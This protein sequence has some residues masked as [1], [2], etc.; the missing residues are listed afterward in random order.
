MV[1][2]R[3]FAFVTLFFLPALQAI[4]IDTEAPQLQAIRFDPAVVDVTDGPA[5]VRIEFDIT[6][7]VSGFRFASLR[8]EFG[9]TRFITGFFGD[10]IYSGTPL[11]GTYVSTQ[12]IPFGS[13][14]GERVVSIILVDNEGREKLYNTDASFTVMNRGDFDREKPTVNNLTIEPQVV[15]LTNGP[16]EVTISIE[17]SDDFTGVQQLF[18][19][20]NPTD[21]ASAYIPDPARR[22]WGITEGNERATI[23]FRKLLGAYTPAGEWQLTLSNIIDGVNRA[24]DY[25]N[26]PEKL[27]KD[28]DA[29]FE[30]INPNSDTTPPKLISVEFPETVANTVYETSFLPWR[31]TFED[32]PSGVELVSVALYAPSGAENY[33]QSGAIY[34]ELNVVDIYGDTF[35]GVIEVPIYIQEGQHRVQVLM[36]DVA[37]NRATYGYGSTKPLP[38]G[39]T[40]FITVEESAGTDTT[41]ILVTDFSLSPDPVD[42]SNGPQIVTFKLDFED[43]L[44][45]LK[46][47]YLTIKDSNG[48]SIERATLNTDDL[49]SGTPTNGTLF[50]AFE[51]PQFRP[52]GEYRVT[53]LTTIDQA[54]NYFTDSSFPVFPVNLPSNF[55]VINNGPVETEP[56][57]ILSFEFP[58]TVIEITG[59]RQRFPVIMRAQ[60][61]LSGIKWG[62]V[63]YALEDNSEEIIRIILSAPRD[64]IGEQ[65]LIKTFENRG[66]FR[67][68]DVPGTYR[69]SELWIQDNFGL[70]RDYDIKDV[71][72]LPPGLPTELTLINPFPAD[73]GPPQFTDIRLSATEFDVSQYPGSLT[74]EIDFTEDTSGLDGA[75]IDLYNRDEFYR[76]RLLSTYSSSQDLNIVSGDRFQGTLKY[77]F[78]I[79]RFIPPGT[80]EVQ[81]ELQDEAFK[82]TSIDGNDDDFPF[83]DR[84]YIMITNTGSVDFSDPLLRDLTIQETVDVSN[85]PAI[86]DISVEAID[87][88]AGVGQ[89]TLQTEGPSGEDSEIEVLYPQSE[90]GSPIL[91]GRFPLSIE[92]PAFAEPGEWK[93]KVT[94]QDKNNGYKKY[95][96]VDLKRWG[97]PS[98]LTVINTQPP[99]YLWKESDDVFPGGWREV[100]WFGW[101]Q[102]QGDYPFVYHLE[103]GWIY[104]S[105]SRLE[106]FTFY[107]TALGFWWWISEDNYPWMYA[108]AG[109]DAGWYYYYAPYGSPGNR[110][111]YDPKSG[112][113]L[114]E[115]TLFAN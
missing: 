67:D 74:V 111:F 73:Y 65:G 37:G 15:D 10:S 2:I 99:G 112:Q 92:I 88:L 42:I 69:L 66:V 62:W 53:S 49:L 4:A 22:R 34:D 59:N 23:V 19:D 43:N 82:D 115:S 83:P 8:L 57:E 31:V 61:D 97:F 6:D 35:E 29:T 33:I 38:P 114:L 11:D 3:F 76:I 21:P 16:E 102:D 7:D 95:E 96:S 85:G 1:L 50:S 94:L 28:F 9:R 27:N 72:S 26:D 64:I 79:P 101:V 110:W 77:I 54:G 39:S 86:V 44:S 105:G 25:N 30:V 12:T 56:P 45:G 18:A 36:Q 78:E 14:P 13:P 47:M 46:I 63:E 51:I 81:Y 20:I 32:L 80:Y 75:F 103:H 52:V 89:I 106:Q 109:P 104:T 5:E 87:N 24:S 91:E 90:D 41:D 98:T 71:S 55:T 113:P 60:D 68:Y 107:E 84:G 70:K 48:D 93:L 58:Q 17:V 40:E 108:Y 100:K